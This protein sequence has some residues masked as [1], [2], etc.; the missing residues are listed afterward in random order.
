M[1]SARWATRSSFENSVESVIGSDDQ[2]ETV[3][4]AVDIRNAL[5]ENRPLRSVDV[6]SQ[7]KAAGL[8]VD[9]S[10]SIVHDDWLL[11]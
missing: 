2:N 3:F 11:S 8:S 7:T 6:S 5:S 1:I 9:N 4:V 10:T